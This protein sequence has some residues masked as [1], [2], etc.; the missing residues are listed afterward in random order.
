MDK[1]TN[2]QTTELLNNNNLTVKRVLIVADNVSMNMGGEASLP[3]YYFNLLQARNIDTW[4]ICHGRVEKELRLSLSTEQLKRCIFIKDSQFQA[5]LWKSGFAFPYR[6]KD[7]IFSQMIHFITQKRVQS[8]A[9]KIIHDFDIQ[10][11]F[12][13]SPITP[14]GISFMYNMGVPVVIGPLCGGLEF[15]P[16]FQFLDS[17]FSHMS[18]GLGRRLSYILHQ[19]IPGKLQAE[20]L[21]VANQRTATALPSGYRGKVYEVV[22][23]GIDKS[24]WDS[25]SPKSIFNQD[26]KIV[27]FV[28]C[29][30]FVDWKGVEF[31]IEAF[32]QVA[33]ETDS[34]LELVGD[35]ELRTKIEAKVKDLK[36]EQRV[37]IHGWKTREEAAAIVYQCDV[38]VM[39]SL[40]ECGGT[41]L[42]EA[43]AL[44]MPI[45]TT[46]WAGPGDYMTPECGILVEPS[47]IKG[48]IDGLAEAM[49]RLSQ[50]PEL[51]FE[52]GQ[53]GIER[54][55]TNYYDWNAKTDRIVQI[56]EETLRSYGQN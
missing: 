10:L 35:G 12:E 25:H 31:L 28:Y 29:G 2:I 54:V 53:H 1:S 50:S 37:I 21:I 15:P 45:I 39:P 52:M 40:R 7:L 32:A 38:F 43:M 23:S 33:Q 5:L 4:L 56:F 27:H 6:I 46:K 48:F 3:F 9:K 17:K 36:L 44:G 49:I 20:T 8:L 42:L 51:R 14:K 19:L 34:I 11:V 41:A 55:K 18:I 30:R 13:P 22:E 47:S 16:A 26:S 24:I